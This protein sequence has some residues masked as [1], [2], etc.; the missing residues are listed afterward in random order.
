MPIDIILQPPDISVKPLGGNARQTSSTNIPTHTI[1]SSRTSHLHDIMVPRQHG[2][3]KQVGIAAVVHKTRNV[4]HA[5]CIPPRTGSR[6]SL[7]AAC[8]M[9]SLLS[10]ILGAACWLRDC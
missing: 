2:L 4:A 6:D 3:H 8:C 1:G 5:G 9:L 10:S 7:R